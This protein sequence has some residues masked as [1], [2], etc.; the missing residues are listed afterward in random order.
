MSPRLPVFIE[1]QI[2]K[3]LRQIYSLAKENLFTVGAIL[4]IEN[5]LVRYGELAAA[6]SKRLVSHVALSVSKPFGLSLPRLALTDM[7]TRLVAIAREGIGRLIEWTRASQ[8]SATDVADRSIVESH[9]A[10]S[11]SILCLEESFFELN[12]TAQNQMGVKKYVWLTRQ[13]KRVRA[14]RYSAINYGYH[15]PLEGQIC[16][17]D[18][19][20]LTADKATS[21]K[22]C[23]AGQDVGCRC[24]ACPYP[25][26]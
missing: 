10:T 15:A 25:G 24:V 16:D 1:N 26:S 4:D 17:W 8:R 5:H 21:K 11:R 7:A 18:K 22:P 6:W 9:I 3:R 20:P 19:P 14:P 12:R 13:D 2:R 23:H